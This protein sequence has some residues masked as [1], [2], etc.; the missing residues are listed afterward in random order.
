MSPE[1]QAGVALLAAMAAGTCCPVNVQNTPD[2][3]VAELQAFRVD[4]A[5]LLD[6]HAVTAELQEKL[7]ASG[8]TV[9]LLH[10]DLETAG[11]FKLEVCVQ[12]MLKR[13]TW[14]LQRHWQA[15]GLLLLFF[16]KELCSGESIRGACYSFH[17]FFVEK[18]YSG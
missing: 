11:L 13:R 6:D 5:I 10:P 7:L 15:S 9:V 16:Y 3:I 2:E 8:L 18:L 1:M 4:G 12:R 17:H 14:V